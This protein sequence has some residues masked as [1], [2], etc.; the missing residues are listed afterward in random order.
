MEVRFGK[1]V[2]E[3]ETTPSYMVL[4]L[5]TISMVVN[6]VTKMCQPA[7]FSV[8]KLDCEGIDQR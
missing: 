5:D 7:G 3:V 8:K 4:R 2:A 6:C 1:V